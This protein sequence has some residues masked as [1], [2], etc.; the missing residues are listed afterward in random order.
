MRGPVTPSMS[1]NRM[2]PPRREE[3]PT[4]AGGG[5]FRGLW[6]GLVI[7]TGVSWKRMRRGWGLLG[8]SYIVAGRGWD[9]RD[10]CG[11]RRPD[12]PGRMRGEDS[13]GGFAGPGDRPDKPPWDETFWNIRGSHDRPFA[14][15]RVWATQHQ[16]GHLHPNLPNIPEFSP[17]FAHDNLGNAGTGRG[18]GPSPLPRA[19]QPRRP[20]LHPS[21]RT[22]PRWKRPELRQ[23]P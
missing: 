8:T 23:D 22:G 14:G 11:D 20:H 5:L 17:G 1:G 12:V 19:A 2:P 15:G 16:S 6:P 10:P 9:W 7:R 21:E 18:I 13:R 3:N 4:G